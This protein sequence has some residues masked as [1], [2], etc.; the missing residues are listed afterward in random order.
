M[1]RLETVNLLEAILLPLNCM[2]GLQDGK[3]IEI[4]LEEVG[5]EVC[6]WV[7]TDKQ[8]LQENILCLLSNATK[9]STGGTVTIAARLG[10]CIRHVSCGSA[11]CIRVEVEDTGIGIS[12][13]SMA[14]LFAPFK[15]AQ[16]LT[17]GTGLGE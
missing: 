3:A 7:I 11:D 15:Q 13:D 9:F 10:G 1:P 2:R 17:G 4:K 16:R 8:W 5:R 6:P 14:T 12:K